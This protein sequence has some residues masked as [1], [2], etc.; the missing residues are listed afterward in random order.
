MKNIFEILRAEK[1]SI[2]ALYFG[3]LQVMPDPRQNMYYGNV[4]PMPIL[5][6]ALNPSWL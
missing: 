6:W 3:I 4:L 2:C 5:L 1:L